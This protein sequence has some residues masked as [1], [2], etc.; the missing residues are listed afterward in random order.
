[1]TLVRP[2]LEYGSAIWHPSQVTLTNSIESLQNSAARF[3]LSDCSRFS[4]VSSMIANLNLSL[5]CRRPGVSRISLPPKILYTPTL[6]HTLLCPP[7]YIPSCLD[8]SCKTASTRAQE[9]DTLPEAMVE[10]DDLPNVIARIDDTHEFREADTSFC[11]PPLTF[12]TAA[13]VLKIK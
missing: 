12:A 3:I 6:K 5:L 9:S 2:K 1:M 10:R 8:H 11:D 13:R 7:S 4:S